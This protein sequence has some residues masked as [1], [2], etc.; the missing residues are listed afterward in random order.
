MSWANDIAAVMREND[1][2]LSGTKIKLAVMTGER[3]VRSG[4]LNLS[5]E[6]L[7]IP[8]R[9]LEKS[10]IKVKETAADGGGLCTDQSSYSEPLKAGDEVLIC[11]LSDSK[12]AI[13][14]RV[15]RGQ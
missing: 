1:Q 7:Y 9:L 10:C 5:A 14:E 6:D 12:F 13:L 8:D 3:S 2:A 15:V 4:N 11:Q